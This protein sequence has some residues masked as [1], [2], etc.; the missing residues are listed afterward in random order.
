MKLLGTHFNI[1]KISYPNSNIHHGKIKADLLLQDFPAPSIFPIQMIK[2]CAQA[3]A[4]ENFLL[5]HIRHFRYWRNL[6]Q[7]E[8]NLLIEIFL[9]QMEKEGTGIVYKIEAAAFKIGKPDF[10]YF[11]VIAELSPIK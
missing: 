5:S 9:N 11:E 4:H 3:M 10:K 8:P 6:K 2:E 1:K 7:E